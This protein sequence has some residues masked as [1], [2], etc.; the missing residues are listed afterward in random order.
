MLIGSSI[1][2]A[3]ALVVTAEAS[4]GPMRFPAPIVVRLEGGSDSKRA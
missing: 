3:L 1:V 4:L 2:A